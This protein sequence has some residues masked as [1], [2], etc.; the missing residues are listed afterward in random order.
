M[1]LNANLTVSN[2][3]LNCDDDEVNND[4]VKLVVFIL[5]AFGFFHDGS[6]IRWNYIIKLDEN[7]W[8]LI[9]IDVSYYHTMNQVKSNEQMSN[10]D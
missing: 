6:M 10:D 7:Q 3:G 5:E 2:L 4:E 8:N 9:W 1:Y